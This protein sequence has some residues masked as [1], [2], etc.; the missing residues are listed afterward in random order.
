MT[1]SL[2]DPWVQLLLGVIVLL[3]VLAVLRFI[4]GLAA[5]LVALGCGLIALLALA[6][7]FWNMFTAR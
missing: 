5:R 3:V 4:I 6:W 2:S 7:A 1:L